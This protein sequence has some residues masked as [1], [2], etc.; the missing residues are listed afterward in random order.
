MQEE[1]IISF[2]QM[3]PSP[4]VEARIRQKIGALERLHPRI[5]SC[6]VVVEKE[7]HRH[8]KG[9]LFRVSV[10]VGIP[11][12]EVVVDRTG[13]KDH[14][15]EDV[16]VALRDAFNATARRLEDVVRVRRGDVKTHALPTRGEVVRLFPEDDYGFVRTSDGQEVYF[17]RHSVVEDG[18][19]RL[20]VGSEVRLVVAET[21]GERGYQASTVHVGAGAAQVR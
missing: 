21:E 11:G 14:A 15:H 16:Y 12:R 18:F 1:P 5:T 3:A 19:D 2:R 8:R 10:D 9:D 7:Q 17:H 20:E 4:A 6:R 13:P